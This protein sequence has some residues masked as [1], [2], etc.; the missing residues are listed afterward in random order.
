[1]G[2]KKYTYLSLILVEPRS[3][4]DLNREQVYSLEKL[5]RIESIISAPNRGGL[6]PPYSPFYIVK[7]KPKSILLKDL[8][9]HMFRNRIIFEKITQ[10]ELF[11]KLDERT[12]YAR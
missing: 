9:L 1:M 3:G 2:E 7:F 4:E 12:V 8:E 10:T 5:G 11:K 6:Y